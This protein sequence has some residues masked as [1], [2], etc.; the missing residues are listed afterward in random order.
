MLSTAHTVSLSSEQFVN[1]QAQASNAALRIVKDEW[2]QRTASAMRAALATADRAK[3][4]TEEGVM[5]KYKAEGN[6]LRLLLIRVNYTMT[7]TLLDITRASLEAYAEY[8]LKNCEAHVTV[9]AV[10]KVTQQNIKNDD[11]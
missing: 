10:D 11:S 7:D 4:N 1:A 9:N 3:Y 6:L 2:P 5:A 8:I